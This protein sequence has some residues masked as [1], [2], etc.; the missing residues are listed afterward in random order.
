MLPDPIETQ[1]LL[2]RPLEAN[3][4]PAV[5]AYTSNPAVMFFMPEGVMTAEQTQ[6]FILNHSKPEEMVYAAVLK[7]ENRLIGYLNFHP[8]F[9]ERIWEI[10]WVFHPDYHGRGYATEA[11][12][13][14]LEYGFQQM[15]VHR[16]IATCQ[17]Q[18]PGSYRVMEKIGMLREGHLRQCIA[19]PDGTW[20][21]E[22]FYAIL[23][24]EWFGRA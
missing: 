15:N 8:W 17:P 2:V 24:E 6:E 9:A 18:N 20:W 22:Y 11:A 5:H 16:V 14:L 23:A 12:A 13:A 10:G 21:D 7:S 4:W 3:D 1:R 19:R